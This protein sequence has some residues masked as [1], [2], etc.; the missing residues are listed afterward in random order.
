MMKTNV[1][2]RWFWSMTLFLT[3]YLVNYGIFLI[4]KDQLVDGFISLV[5]IGLLW[6]TILFGFFPRSL[7]Q[8]N[9]SAKIWKIL[10]FLSLSLG[11]FFSMILL[12]INLITPYS[13][14]GSGFLW[15]QVLTYGG[16][17]LTIILIVFNII[18]R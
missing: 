5:A 11:S 1:Q 13:A 15:E 12:W 6:L 10:I 2:K 7:Y 18:K 17:L 9:L 14:Q 16:C 8:A 3:W 4:A